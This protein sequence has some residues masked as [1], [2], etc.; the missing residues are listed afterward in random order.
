MAE[1]TERVIGSSIVALNSADGM[2]E[3]SP[4][5][6]PAFSSKY[7]EQKVRYKSS[8]AQEYLVWMIAMNSIDRVN[9]EDEEDE[10]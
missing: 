8:N 2:Y 9:D 1:A 5:D 3:V 7:Y 6:F 10:I 4:Q